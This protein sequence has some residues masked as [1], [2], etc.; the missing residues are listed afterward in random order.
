MSIFGMIFLPFAAHRFGDERGFKRGS[1]P[2][3]AKRV[4]PA[5]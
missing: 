3:S 1:K 2:R 5:R 4:T